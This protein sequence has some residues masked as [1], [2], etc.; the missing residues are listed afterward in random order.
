MTAT[1]TQADADNLRQV[2]E[3][4]IQWLDE[5]KTRYVFTPFMS[6]SCPQIPGGSVEAGVITSI[7]APERNCLTYVLGGDTSRILRKTGDD[8]LDVAT[9]LDA[10]GP[11]ATGLFQRFGAEGLMEIPSLAGMPAAQF[12][13]AQINEKLFGSIPQTINRTLTAGGYRTRLGEVLLAA[14]SSP[15]GRMVAEIARQVLAAIERCDQ[16]CQQQMTQRHAQIKD[17][18]SDVP[19][20]YSVRD[21]RMLEFAGLKPLEEQ[22]QEVVN[23][24]TAAIVSQ[25]RATEEILRKMEEREQ[26]AAQR[27]AQMM[28]LFRSM[29]GALDR[30][31]GNGNGAADGEGDKNGETATAAPKRKLKLSP[32]YQAPVAR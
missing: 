10:P 31:G 23:N 24:Q 9:Y 22:M 6:V 25:S 26:Q 28:E 14:D 2:E 17:I 30:I 1:A 19:K 12:K 32:D 4:H 16:Y 5:H 18:T 8:P 20:R 7:Q 13:A 21:R 27:E 3:R 15:G 11:I 29:V